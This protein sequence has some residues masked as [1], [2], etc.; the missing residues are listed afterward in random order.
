[1]KV[2]V[3]AALDMTSTVA[4]PQAPT[5]EVETLPKAG[6]AHERLD[7]GASCGCWLSLTDT[8]WPRRDCNAKMTGSEAHIGLGVASMSRLASSLSQLAPDEQK[9]GGPEPVRKVSAERSVRDAKR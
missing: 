6:D 1:M 3:A 8:R 4:A 5:A 2:R 9:K 7:L